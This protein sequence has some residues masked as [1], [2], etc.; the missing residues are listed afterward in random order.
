MAILESCELKSIKVLSFEEQ[1]LSFLDFQNNS[2]KPFNDNRGYEAYAKRVYDLAQ[3]NDRCVVLFNPGEKT[4]RITG[5][6]PEKIIK[7]GLLP[8]G[9]SIR[10]SLDHIWFNLF[11]V[12]VNV[13]RVFN[14]VNIINDYF[15]KMEIV[16]K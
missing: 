7:Q 4:E 10:Y 9:D 5:F 2:I 13:R 11:D 8:I 14:Y 16:K 3:A 1:L 15:K 6:V 12:E